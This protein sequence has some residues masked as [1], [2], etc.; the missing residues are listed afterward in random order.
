[1][2]DRKRGSRQRQSGDEEWPKYAPVR[3]ELQALAR[4]WA[5]VILDD[6][7]WEFFYGTPSC[8]CAGERLDAIA[9]VAGQDMVA[10]AVAEAEKG[11][12]EGL[13]EEC[14]R[15]FTSGSPAEREAVRDSMQSGSERPARSAG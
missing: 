5:G 7:L 9:Q 8:A 2:S 11:A 6:R 3:E 1:M 14:W 10:E 13:G 15:I 12:R 4:Y